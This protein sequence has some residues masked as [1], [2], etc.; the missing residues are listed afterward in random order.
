MFNRKKKKTGCETPE[1]RSKIPMP[2]INPARENIGK[3]INKTYCGTKDR[4]SAFLELYEDAIKID[5]EIY[6]SDRKG[7]IVFFTTQEYKDYLI[8]RSDTISNTKENN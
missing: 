5:G 3:R 4:I 7:V 1:F 6:W 8:G 2:P